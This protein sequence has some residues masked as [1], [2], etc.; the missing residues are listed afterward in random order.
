MP[1]QLPH[2]AG[3]LSD[4]G[5]QRPFPGYDPA[6]ILPRGA[7]HELA[8]ALRHERL[9]KATGTEDGAPVTDLAAISH[10]APSEADA[11]CINAR[12]LRDELT[13]DGVRFAT[14]SDTEVVA[15]MIANENGATWDERALQ[16]LGEQVWDYFRGA[17]SYADIDVSFGYS[18]I[19]V[20]VHWPLDVVGG[21]LLGIATALLLLAATRRR[22]P[23]R[24]RSG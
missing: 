19:Y 22:S 12:D 3:D 14:S 8:Q 21:A 2:R 15:Q 7:W 4:L 20:G 6:H 17:R 13:R 10:A 1:G 24:P 16:A 5:L 9:A 18:R 11:N 23:R